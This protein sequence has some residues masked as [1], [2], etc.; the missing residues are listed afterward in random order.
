MLYHQ[1]LGLSSLTDILRG[2]V[3]FVKNPMLCY[4]DTIDWDLI[5]RFPKGPDAKKEEIFVI[6]VSSL[7]FQTKLLLHIQVF[8]TQNGLYY[9][10]YLVQVYPIPVLIFFFLRR[11][12]PLFYLTFC[13][14]SLS[15]VHTSRRCC[16]LF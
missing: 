16:R 2:G 12:Q 7:S 13:L 14:S 9:A 3:Y 10:W 8:G 11:W 6:R 1:E 5:G 15:A 4:I